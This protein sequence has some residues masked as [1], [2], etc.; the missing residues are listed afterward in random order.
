MRGALLS[1]IC[2]VSTR[3]GRLVKAYTRLACCSCPERFRG[4]IHFSRLLPPAT[5][6]AR[7]SLSP[8]SDAADNILRRYA[9]PEIRDLDPLLP[10]LH[11][12]RNDAMPLLPLRVFAFRNDDVVQSRRGGD[13]RR[14]RYR[15]RRRS[16]NSPSRKRRPHEI[17]SSRRRFAEATPQP[18]TR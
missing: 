4:R 6:S 11:K 17:A 18:K 16:N 9:P 1:A 2:V 10:S 14:A 8:G 7:W 3:W 12:S 5:H 15:G 13:E